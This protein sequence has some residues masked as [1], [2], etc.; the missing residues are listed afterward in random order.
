LVLSALFG[1]VS[2]VV[3]VLVSGVVSKM[4][5][6]PTFILVAVGFFVLS[7]VTV[8]CKGLLLR[9]AQRRTASGFGRPETI[10]HKKTTGQKQK[11]EQQ[12]RF[13]T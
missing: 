9:M 7:G 1:V 10:R 4:P 12:F 6:G 3:G 13:L 5:T 11:P 8:W 2:S